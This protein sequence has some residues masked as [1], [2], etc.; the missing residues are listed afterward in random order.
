MTFADLE[1]LHGQPLLE[2]KTL[3]DVSY[4]EACVKYEGY[5]D[6]QKREVAKTKKMART[7]IPAD[8]DYTAV[9]GL[10]SEIRHKLA[11]ARPQS[12]GEAARVAHE[13]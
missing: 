11:K 10:S 4:I 1:A 13:V 2:K 8:L 5:I 9:A 6:I 7:A 12:L 3:T